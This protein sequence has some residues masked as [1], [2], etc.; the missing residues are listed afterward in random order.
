MQQHNGLKYW[1]SSNTFDIKR[2]QQRLLSNCIDLANAYTIFYFNIW[3]PY[4]ATSVLLNISCTYPD[5]D[6][7]FFAIHWHVQGLLSGTL[8][9]LTFKPHHMSSSSTFYI[10]G[11]SEMLPHNCIMQCYTY[12]R[13]YI[14]YIKIWIQW[15]DRTCILYLIVYMYTWYLLFNHVAMFYGTV[16]YI[17]HWPLI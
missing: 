8:S 1:H 15:P 13:K 12:Y 16:Y 11:G 9:L 17:L 10:W 14:M 7:Q 4:T 2:S 6:M 5:Q 3:N